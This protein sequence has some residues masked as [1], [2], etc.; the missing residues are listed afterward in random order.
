MK[1]RLLFPLALVLAALL[2]YEARA[3]EAA[4]DTAGGTTGQPWVVY[5]GT[6]GPGVGQHVV[7]V[8]GDEEYRSEEGMPMLAR[9]LAE[10]HGFTC[11]VLFAIDPET[12]LIN[13]DVQTNIPGLERL[14]TADLMVLFTRFRELPD[15]QMKHI[16]DY[17]NSG[18]PIVGLRTSTHA[19]NYTRDTTNAYAKY[20]YRS[21]EP[22]GGYG[23]AVFGETWINHHGD[24]GTE[25]TRGLING[26]HAGHPILRGVGDIW[27]PTDVY[28]VRPLVGDPDVLVFGQV[29]EG[30]EPTAMPNFEKAI[31]PVAWV[32][33]YTGETGNTA[34]VFATTMGA[35]V[36][37][38]SEGLRRLLV[39]AV[40]WGLEMEEEIPEA[41]NVAIVGDYD[42]TF[43]GFGDYRKG[44]RP[45]DFER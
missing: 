9:I 16:I 37:L 12:G 41:A 13:P 2:A 39:N 19:F 8:T 7:F 17:T 27:G 45:S 10:H 24:H 34:R 5:E 30:M 32:K 44:L 3:Q 33:D 25:S 40:Y 22:E 11:T 23:R 28:G 43:F 1:A 20:D 35:A 26:L 42:P 6:Q 14:E 15:E 29:L 36:D 38:E 21:D 4:Q 18:K 31:M